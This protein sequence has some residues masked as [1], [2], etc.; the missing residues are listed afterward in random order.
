[1]KIDSG[2]ENGGSSGN[3]DELE[4]DRN[5]YVVLRRKH[6]ELYKKVTYTSNK[7]EVVDNITEYDIRRANTSVL[8][9]TNKLKEETI[10]AIEALPG[11]D[12]KVIIG[13]MERLDPKLKKVIAKEIKMAKLMLFQ[14][15][16]IMDDDILSIKNDAIFIIGRRL[17]KTVFGDIEFRAKNKYSAYIAYEGLEVYYNSKENK[18]DLKG[19]SDEIIEHTDH[20]NGMLRFLANVM[21]YIS[22]GQKDKL[23]KYLISFTEDYKSMNL[24]VEYYREMNKENA[25]RTKMS[26]GKYCLNLDVVNDDM[27]DMIDGIYN[28]SRFVLPLIQIYI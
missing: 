11:I 27:K 2:N 7:K 12:R 19:V 9:Q 6:S 20:Q 8:R 13:K 26:I 14:S 1:M 4:R 17:K 25:Y 5:G 22:L 21:R 3:A 16:G 24:P 18:V 15:N 23:R 28:Y 10:S